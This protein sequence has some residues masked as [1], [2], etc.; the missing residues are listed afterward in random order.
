[1]N[2]FIKIFL[3]LSF[4][5][6]LKH[7]VQGCVCGGFTSLC[8]KLDQISKDSIPLPADLW[9]FSGRVIEEVKVDQGI[10]VEVTEFFHGNTAIADTVFI[11]SGS[12]SIC[13]HNTRQFEIGKEYLFRPTLAYFWNV[14]MPQR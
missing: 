14:W 5:L 3:I 10:L 9:L 4:V 2:G 7:Q 11:H 12:S 1:M 13:I 6:S 8:N